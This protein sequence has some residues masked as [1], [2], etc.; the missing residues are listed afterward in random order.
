MN[1][2]LKK[3]IRNEHQLQKYTQLTQLASQVESGVIVELGTYLGYGTIALCEGSQVPVYT[4]D[5]YTPKTGWAGEFYGPKDIQVFHRNC[6][7]A[8]VK[9]TLLMGDAGEVA[10]EI[11]RFYGVE[12]PVSFLFWDL[13]IPARLCEDFEAWQSHITGKFVIHDTD[14]NRLGSDLLNPVGW[15]KRKEGVFW[16]LERLKTG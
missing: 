12:Y 3:V 7:E 8:N 9:P 1:P 2:L 11:K 13:G 14:D 5:D 16:I 6:D 10:D 15:E 4:V